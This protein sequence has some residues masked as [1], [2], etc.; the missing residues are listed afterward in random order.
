MALIE[1]LGWSTVSRSI[2]TFGV[3]G[4]GK[5]SLL[6]VDIVVFVRLFGEFGFV[7]N[8]RIHL[9]LQRLCIGL[10]EVSEGS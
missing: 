3:S 1:G 6:G 9:D 10:R 4:I 2:V 8:S 5:F 7:T